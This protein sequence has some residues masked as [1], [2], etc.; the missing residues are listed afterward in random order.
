MSRCSI[1]CK[2]AN[3]KILLQKLKKYLT[4]MWKLIPL[5]KYVNALVRFKQIH[6]H[7]LK[8]ILH[9]FLCVCVKTCVRVSFF[10]K[11]KIK[12]IFIF[13]IC[14]K[15]WNFV[16]RLNLSVTERIIVVCVVV[17]VCE[18]VCFLYF[19]SFLLHIFRGSCRVLTRS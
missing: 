17:N 7:I 13:L 1:T 3:I 18:C 19:H 8:Q 5:H 10:W 2:E 6:L 12:N 4:W 14:L 11:K 15:S 16:E 9:W